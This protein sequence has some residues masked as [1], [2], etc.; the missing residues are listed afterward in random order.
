MY[1]KDIVVSVYET[2]PSL[3]VV[4]TT[5][6]GRRHILLFNGIIVI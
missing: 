1:T 3:L 2:L 5:E 4:C 6:N